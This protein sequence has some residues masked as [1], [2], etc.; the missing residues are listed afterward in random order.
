MTH[1]PNDHEVDFKPTEVFYS[2][3]D[4]RGVIRSGNS[5]FLRVSG[6]PPDQLIGAP[7]KIIRHPDMPKGLFHLFWRR[8]GAGQPVLAFVKNRAA[9]G[10]HYWTLSLACPNGDGYLSVRIKPIGPLFAKIPALYASLLEAEAAGT[11]PEGSET[12]LLAKLAEMGFPSYEAFMCEALRTEFAERRKRGLGGDVPFLSHHDRISD[13]LRRLAVEQDALI[14][15]LDMMHLLPTNMRILAGR[16]EASGGP[17][18]AVSETYRLAVTDIFETL[19]RLGQDGGKGTDAATLLSEALFS[20]GALL[21][22]SACANALETEMRG[23]GDGVAQ[24]AAT[25]RG[26]TESYER[27]AITRLQEIAARTA[28]LGHRCD[29]LRR[30]MIG[31]DQIRIMG[32]IESGRMPGRS[33]LSILMEQLAQYHADIRA[34]LMVLIS[35][36]SD[37]QS[38]ALQSVA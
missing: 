29:E 2:R 34:R 19:R 1:P 4:S 8:L 23:G 37:L 9:D 33:E 24:E 5:V 28:D 16:L 12:A 26:L 6:Y 20:I 15:V 7:H 38:R 36:A 11:S 13:G 21:I 25:M 35:L 14:G 27:E 18:S 10:R 30:K 3:T 32:D 31:L 22:Y 17:V